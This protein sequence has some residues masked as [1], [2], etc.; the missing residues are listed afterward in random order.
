MERALFESHRN[1]VYVYSSCN[2]CPF[3][4]RFRRH[5]SDETV[6][7]FIVS[8]PLLPPSLSNR[9][10]HPSSSLLENPLYPKLFI[11]SIYI[12]LSIPLST[13][14]SPHTSGLSISIDQLTNSENRKAKR[15]KPIPPLRARSLIPYYGF[16]DLSYGAC[17]LIISPCALTR[18]VTVINY[19]RRYRWLRYTFETS[20]RA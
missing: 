9:L 12:R 18:I 11:Y 7:F 15:Y 16:N 4:L 3:V 5:Y 20:G 2:F 17:Q 19:H 8:P 6:E 1:P 10:I 13:C 14:P